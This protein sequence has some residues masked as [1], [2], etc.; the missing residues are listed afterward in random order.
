MKKQVLNYVE[1][2]RLLT[3]SFGSSK[4]VLVVCKLLDVTSIEV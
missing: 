4:A 2:T 3:L 1:Q